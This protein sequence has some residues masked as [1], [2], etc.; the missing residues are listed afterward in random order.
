VRGSTAL[1]DLSRGK[2]ILLV[3]VARGILDRL[4]DAGPNT[5]T[6]YDRI[7]RSIWGRS[8]DFAIT[9]HPPTID[10]TR[11][12]LAM[13]MLPEKQI[14]FPRLNTDFAMVLLLTFFWIFLIV[15]INAKGDF[16]LNDDWAYGWT[17]KTLLETGT[18]Q[19]S[20]WAAPNLVSQVIFG[21]LFCLPFGFS[22]TA[23]RLSTLTLGLIGILVTYGVLREVDASPKLSLL[24]ALIIALNPLYFP[25]SNSFMTDVP[26]FT[27]VISSLYFLMRGLRR[28][29]KLEM[30]IGI[31]LAFTAILNRQSS[32]IILPAFSLAYL[33]KNGLKRRTMIEAWAPTIMGLA[34]Y[35]SYSTWLKLSGRAPIVY[36]LHVGKILGTLSNGFWYT[37][38]QYVH[39][40]FI[41]SIYL[42]LFLFPFLIIEFSS[43]YDNLIARQKQVCLSAFAIMA[44]VAI[45]VAKYHR[46][47]RRGNMLGPFGIQPDELHDYQSFLQPTLTLIGRTWQ[48]VTVLGVFGA[49]LLFLYSLYNM[50]ELLNKAPLCSN[51]LKQ[52]KYLLIFV[53]LLIALYFLPIGALPDS[54][55]F[56][57][58]LILFLPLLMMVVSM[59]T[60]TLNKGK[61][62]SVAVSI[63]AILVLC[64]GA[65][66]ISAT[67]DYLAWNRVRWQA[68]NHLV[69]DLRVSPDQIYGGFEFVGWYFGNKI[70]TCN[71]V[72]KK[73]GGQAYGDLAD[74]KCFSYNYNDH[75][76]YIV[77]FEPK[78]D[79]DIK[80]RY[81]F[82][83]WLP[84]R[85][86]D[87]YVLHAVTTT[88]GNY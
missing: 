73:N 83:S 61:L 52:K 87:L 35:I 49:G 46:M 74:F 37:A 12:R 38:S 14:N 80:I 4:H 63:S 53:T 85:K 19:L 82:S 3:L 28:D 51:S 34:L 16:P 6:G 44:P 43:K 88:T 9:L 47:P 27:F 81:S 23:L 70:A 10:R 68:L 2:L 41:I 24:G 76:Q 22:F 77:S 11:R 78:A 54:Y 17:V 58:H 5:V 62:S 50:I 31:L 25:L 15:L 20:D 40:L 84:P 45:F 56:D 65:F 66:T 64:L 69:Q 71:P 13:G 57:R 18:F 55:W 30:S 33:T 86:Q 26:S 8:H 42:G 59:S 29:S 7:A 21:A 79:Y 67:H 1:A 39:N 75:Y 48:L 36:N 32:L 72:Y 60:T